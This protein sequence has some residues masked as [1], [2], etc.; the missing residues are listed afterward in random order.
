[1][2]N[3]WKRL[4][5]ALAAS[6]LIAAA[7]TAH[8]GPPSDGLSLR[9]VGL[10]EA[11]SSSGGSTCTVPSADEGILLNSDQI[12]LWTTDGAATRGY[13]LS[14]CGGWMEL[15]NVMTAQGVS[16]DRV[17]IRLRI[18]GAG[19][20]RQY[21][22]T[23]NGF[24]TACLSLRKSTIFAGAHLFP[25]GTDP[26]FGNTGS[27]EPH[28]A[29]VNLFPMVDAQ[30]IGCLREQYA[31]LPANVYTSFPLIIR[32]IASGI[33]D[34]GQQL[35]SNAIKFTLS[36]QHFCGN[37]RVDAAEQCDPNAPGQC[38]AAFCDPQERTCKGDSSIFCTTDA[39][40]Q[41]RCLPEG[42]PNECSCLFGE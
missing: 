38:D 39:D 31:G 17:D 24:P 8:A 33:T 16:I 9:A 18:A 28:I 10:F 20:F 19:R 1:M 35:K 11:E 14:A 29:F 40:C 37:G 7:G 2:N 36:L 34:S 15:Q 30:V 12:G 23:R 5:A 3:R 21:V 32:M 22:P 27:G 41:G 13:P 4:R 6:V 25:L 26:T 42:D